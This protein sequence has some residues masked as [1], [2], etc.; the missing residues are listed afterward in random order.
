MR[1]LYFLSF[2]NTE[3]LL[4]SFRVTIFCVL[5]VVISI[6]LLITWNIGPTLETIHKQLTDSV[7]NKYTVSPSIPAVLYQNQRFSCFSYRPSLTPAKILAGMIVIHTNDSHTVCLSQRPF[8]L[9]WE[10]GP[11]SHAGQI[12]G[13]YGSTHYIYLFTVMGR[14]QFCINQKNRIIKSDS[15]ILHG[16]S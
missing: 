4:R 10:K 7:S 8:W 16:I 6:P 3:A 5:P 14:N 15:I 13:R 9:V 2:Q 11:V 12:T 1:R